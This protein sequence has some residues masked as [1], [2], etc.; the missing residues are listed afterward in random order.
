MVFNG[1]GINRNAGFRKLPHITLH[2]G[3]LVLVRYMAGEAEYLT[4]NRVLMFRITLQVKDLFE[5]FAFP[6]ECCVRHTIFWS[7]LM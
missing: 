4:S 3:L 2:A 7:V 1:N 5:Y 6:Q